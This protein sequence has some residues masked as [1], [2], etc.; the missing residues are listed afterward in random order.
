VELDLGARRKDAATSNRVVL[1][2]EGRVSMS[3]RL[4]VAWR[5]SQGGGRQSAATGEGLPPTVVVASSTGGERLEILLFPWSGRL[6]PA[7][8][9]AER[10]A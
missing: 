4:V 7:V 8:A 5:A 10:V 3:K 6:A 9:A 1:G 2:V